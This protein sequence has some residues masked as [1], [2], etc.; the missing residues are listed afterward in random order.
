MLSSLSA[1]G[2]L[3]SGLV[4][5][6]RPSLLVVGGSGFLGREVARS[7]TRNGW[8]VVSLSRRGT[9]PEPRCPELAQVTWVAGDA[10]DDA[11]LQRLANDADAFVH[12][13]GILFDS[14]SGLA[15]YNRLVSGSG[16]VPSSGATYENAIEG[17]ALPLMRAAEQAGGGPFVF[18][19]AIGTELPVDGLLGKRLPVWLKRYLSSKRSV[20][21]TAERYRERHEEAAERGSASCGV[22]PIVPRP[23]PMWSPTKLD[24]LPV[25]PVWNA[26][27]ALL[28]QVEPMLPAATVGEAIV[29][30][31]EAAADE[32]RVTPSLFLD[33]D[34]IHDL[35]PLTSLKP[36]T[37]L[38]TLTSGFAS[39]ARLPYGTEVAQPL[40]EGASAADTR[41]R[42]SAIT[43][44]EFEG[45]PFCRRV[46]EV[47]TYLDLGDVTIKPCAI[48]SRH[49]EEVKEL[50]GRARPQ[51]PYL[52]DAAAG[53]SLFESADIC[54]HLIHTYG[55]P[56]GVTELPSPSDF[57]LQ[58]TL[59]TGWLPSLF[60]PGRGGRVERRVLGRDP[61]A[62]PLV[63]YSYEVMRP[64]H[65]AHVAPPPVTQALYLVHACTR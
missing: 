13:A 7:A 40:R 3:C 27:A 44:Y 59:L 33:S 20:E 36:V 62:K 60:R 52:V 64:P 1:V 4:S 45:C 46:R 37:N 61:P 54:E 50:S 30:A 19:S 38:D 39:I 10:G 22:L 32:A 21:E 24:V 16:S 63:L 58:S 56:H 53:V 15:D 25:L 11:L 8:A 65:G 5:S 18:V 34:A 43:L 35:V 57:F 6:D 51:F 47:V 28:P 29:E 14:E 41:A 23:A 17:T 49:R 12:A 31:I 48:G 42:G 55:V 2:L 26:A 9:N